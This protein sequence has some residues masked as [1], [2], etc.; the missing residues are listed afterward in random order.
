MFIFFAE[1]RPLYYGVVTTLVPASAGAVVAGAA[2]GAE[3]VEVVVVSTVEVVVGEALVVESVGLELVT[4][5][6]VPPDRGPTSVLAIG[7]GEGRGPTSVVV[8]LTTGAF[9]T[10]AVFVLV[11]V[12]DVVRAAV[13]VVLTVEVMTFETAAVEVA[14]EELHAPVVLFQLPFMILTQ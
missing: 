10:G 12:V 13:E 4:L 8:A 7:V 2:A 6:V 1:V 11:F 3:T 5:E 14:V 9:T